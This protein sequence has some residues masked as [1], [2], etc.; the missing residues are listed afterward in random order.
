MTVIGHS[1]GAQLCAMLLLRRARARR[2]EGDRLRSHRLP[3]AF[4]GSALL[5]LALS[6]IGGLTDK[7]ICLI[8]NAVESKTV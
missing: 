2:T 6:S 8:L 5:M 7:Q 1:A 4:I 3:A